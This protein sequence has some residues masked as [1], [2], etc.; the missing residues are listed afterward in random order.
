MDNKGLMENKEEI[1]LPE[2]KRRDI[3]QMELKVPIDICEC[4]EY[5]IA[6][7]RSIIKSNYRRM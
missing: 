4:V 5:L 7:D 2:N 1:P 3:S 6:N